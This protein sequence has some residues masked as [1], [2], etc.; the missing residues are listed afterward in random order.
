MALDL[1]TAA[2]PAY[3][4]AP[5]PPDAAS[6]SHHQQQQQQQPAAAIP[7][8]YFGNAAWSVSVRS[9]NK[10]GLPGDDSKTA[11]PVGWHKRINPKE[12]QMVCSDQSLLSTSLAAGAMRIRGALQAVR[13][14][15]QFTRKLLQQIDEGMEAPL[16]SQASSGAGFIKAIDGFTTSWQFGLWDIAFG[17]QGAVMFQGLVHPVPPYHA[18]IM[19]SSPASPTVAVA[20]Q[21][22]DLRCNLQPALSCLADDVSARVTLVA[23]GNNSNEAVNDAEV[24]AAAQGATGGVANGRV[25]AQHAVESSSGGMWLWLTVPSCLSPA[26]AESPVLKLLVPDA[27]WQSL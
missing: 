8:N 17:S 12:W 1:R 5:N 3:T 19:P 2:A 25:A 26:M 24:V 9:C 18:V 15:T 21:D 4:S 14:D 11:L 6:H 16:S 20:G 27:S 22:G 7:L 23:D 13:Q 10:D